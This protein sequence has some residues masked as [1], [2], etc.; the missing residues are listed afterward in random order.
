MNAVSEGTDKNYSPTH[1]SDCQQCHS[2]TTT[3]TGSNKSNCLAA[4]GSTACVPEYCGRCQ[5][6]SKDHSGNHN[7]GNN[8]TNLTTNCNLVSKF[9]NILFYNNANQ[10]YWMYCIR[11]KISIWKLKISKSVFNYSDLNQ[12][13]QTAL[14]NL[15]SDETIP[16]TNITLPYH[17]LGVEE[18]PSKKYLTTLYVRGAY[19]PDSES[20]FNTRLSASRYIIER[21]FG[22][23]ANKW[24]I[25]QQAMNFEL[26]T[27]NTIV[28]ALVCLH[29]F[30]ITQELSGHTNKLYTI[31]QH[32]IQE[33]NF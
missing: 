18:L 9:L 27:T 3:I 8:P 28:M 2:A 15:P 17:L 4:Y 14:A 32:N 26:K 16:N 24:K 21:A 29:N 11:Y 22:V 1:L 25:L 10:A 6:S 13:L 23:L 5:Y 19:T 12:I 7:H 30:I 20:N 31:V 33:V